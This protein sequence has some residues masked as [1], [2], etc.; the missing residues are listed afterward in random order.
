MNNQDIKIDLGHS[1]GDFDV[2]SVGKSSRDRE[3]QS[4]RM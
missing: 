4:H 2:A 3:G 1:S